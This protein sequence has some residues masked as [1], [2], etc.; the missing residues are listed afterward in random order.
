MKIEPMQPTL[1][2][3]SH[4][5][6][7]ALANLI[8]INQE[9]LSINSTLSLETGSRIEFYSHYF[10]GRGVIKTVFHQRYQYQYHLCIEEIH[11]RRGIVIDEIL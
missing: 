6:N 8:Y 2:T 5:G 3:V 11:Y 9:E 1:V 4:E 10:C 7:N